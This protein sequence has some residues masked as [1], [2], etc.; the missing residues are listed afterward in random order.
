MP[1]YKLTYFDFPGGRGE[2]CRLALHIAG[3]D[4]EDD[5]VKGP[6]WA[7]R[8]PN[9]PFGSLPVLEV[10]GKGALAQSNTILRYLGRELGLHP[11]DPWEAARHEAVMG[12]VEDLRAQLTALRF[13]GEEDKKKAREAFASGYVQTWAASVAKEIGE[14]PFLA[15]SDLNVADLK[16]FVVMNWFIKGGVDHVPT[17]V[18]KDHPKLM[19][20]FD[21]VRSHEKVADWYAA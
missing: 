16:L 14:G 8:K 12:A 1:K 18:F 5:R 2:D 17:D 7:E 13:D 4:F 3:A 21:A 20:L 15:G 10:E 9:T 6:T 11:R 19:R